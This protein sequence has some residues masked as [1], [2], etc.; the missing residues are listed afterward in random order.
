MART[1]TPAPTGWK[2][3]NKATAPP[4][5]RAQLRRRLT[6]RTATALL[7]VIGAFFL[8]L[9]VAPGGRGGLVLE[10]DRGE[11]LWAIVPTG[12]KDAGIVAAYGTVLDTW[13]DPADPRSSETILAKA[14]SSVTPQARASLRAS[15]LRPIRGYVQGY[16]GPVTF[17]GGR[18][19]SVLQYELSGTYTAV[20]EFDACSSPT[21]AVT[22]TVDAPSAGKLSSEV[23]ALPE[24][25][26]PVCNG[27]AFTSPDRGD[28]AIPL[29]LPA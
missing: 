18:V 16:L 14:P 22:V 24:G 9:L 21:V 8:G 11:N 7:V 2:G 17:A 12:W 10:T 5:R 13:S 26:E 19:V 25:A 20:F 29:H 27:Q 4:R 23:N 28:L 3:A 6:R 1:G 15:Q